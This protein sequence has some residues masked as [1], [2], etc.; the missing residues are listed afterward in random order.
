MTNEKKVYILKKIKIPS[1]DL[2]KTLMDRCILVGVVDKWIEKQREITNGI[3][4]NACSGEI[5][6]MEGNTLRNY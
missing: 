4:L 2:Y 5:I 1:S 6:S 3:I